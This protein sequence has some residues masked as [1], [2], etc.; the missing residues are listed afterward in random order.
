MSECSICI[1]SNVKLVVCNVCS[2]NS[3]VECVNMNSNRC[4]HCNIHIVKQD[5]EKY[6]EIHNQISSLYSTRKLINGEVNTYSSSNV[7]LYRNC[8]VCF[9]LIE[10]QI[11]DCSQ[12]YCTVC[13]TAW[14]WLTLKIVPN[15]LDIHNPHFFNKTVRKRPSTT[16]DNVLNKALRNAFKCLVELDKQEEKYVTD[17]FIERVS[18]IIGNTS[19]DEFVSRISSRYNIRV[20]DDMVKPIL[21][22]FLKSPS[23]ENVFTTN[24]KLQQIDVTYSLSNLPYC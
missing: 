3:C 16:N 15:K 8:P 1:R 11:D 18:N 9:T 10:K 21:E 13:N 14:S 19:F 17:C 22:D 7:P 5:R 20:K 6:K 2:G 23:N 12:I 4:C 24:G